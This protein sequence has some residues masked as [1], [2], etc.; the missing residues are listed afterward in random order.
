M[1]L[2][3]G[4]CPKELQSGSISHFFFRPRYGKTGSKKS[5]KGHRISQKQVHVVNLKV[6]LILRN[7]SLTGQRHDSPN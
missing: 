7:K 5:P 6:R 2:Y 4:Q 3:S 1:Q